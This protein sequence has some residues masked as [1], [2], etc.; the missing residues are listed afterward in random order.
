METN[1]RSIYE[2]IK[3][4]IVG[5]ELPESFSLPSDTSENEVRFA[6]GAIDGIAVY[7]MG[8]AEVS[9]GSMEKLDKLMHS[10]S[11]G[12]FEL[13]FEC[14]SDFSKENTA[15]NA[16]DK[17]EGFIYDNTDW[18]SPENLHKFAEKCLMSR[19]INT[20]KFGMEMIEVLA[21]PDEDIKEIIRTL[22]LCDEFTIFA[23]FNM[24]NWKNGNNEI[25]RLA[26][27]VH[28]WGRIHAVER[29]DPENEEIRSWLLKEGIKNGVMPDYSA[30][31]VYNKAEVRKLLREKLTDDELDS[32]AAII[33]AL[34]SEGPM[35][36]ISAVEDGEEMI[37]AFL[38]QVNRH[39]LDL[40][41]CETVYGIT[42]E[43]FSDDVNSFCAQILNSDETKKIVAD[44]LNDGKGTDL[45]KYL[46]IDYAEPLFRHM[47]SDFEH[48][49]W[50]CRYLIGNYEYREKVLEL[51]RKNLPMEEMGGEP[52][53]CMGIGK[54]YRNCGKLGFLIQEL[55]EYP[56]CGT[57]F[58][59][60]GLKSPVVHNRNTALRV[61]NIWCRTKNCSLR[62][63]SQELYDCVA[64]LK[65]KEVS[66]SVKKNI[67]EYG[68]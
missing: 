9:E 8:Q 30:L 48:G 44:S 39:R 20:V 38:G 53:D 66:D 64:E 68:F 47:T 25:F 46:N 31:E 36:G 19:D 11:D 49:C 32:I 35:S 61:L 6:D 67:A 26:Q 55:K 60:L 59:A 3:E 21:E 15:L 7:H 12:N 51:F 56:L 58:V 29:L 54:K 16:I 50:D 24:R 27:K 43:N 22:G 23:I 28:G 18:I 33:D 34:L 52:S 42:L 62:E 65:K 2:I 13:G 14:L 5:G 45:A 10:V 63:L 40:N 57:D 1:E 17:F 37:L 41:I 4:N